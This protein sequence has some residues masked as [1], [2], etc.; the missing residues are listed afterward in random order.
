M[1]WYRTWFIF[2]FKFYLLFRFNAI[3]KFAQMKKQTIIFKICPKAKHPFKL[4]FHNSCETT[5]VPGDFVASSTINY[6]FMLCI[7][8]VLFSSMPWHNFTLQL[9]SL[10]KMLFFNINYAI[11]KFAQ[12]KKQTIIF[13]ICPKAKH[14]FKL[15]FHN[16]SSIKIKFSHSPLLIKTVAINNIIN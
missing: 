15:S 13:K 4:S 3:W 12:M 10:C 2:I 5:M 9:A 8:Q 14:P 1:F 16:S 7:H 11:W 6:N